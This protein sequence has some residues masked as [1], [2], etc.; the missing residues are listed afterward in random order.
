MNFV[1]EKQLIKFPCTY[2]PLS[3]FKIFIK[4][5]RVDSEDVRHFWDQN[6]PSVLNKIF[7]WYKPL[8]LLSSN[9]GP[10]HCAKFKINLTMDPEL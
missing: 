6:R 1:P 4:E 3:F 8:L 5:L 7:V 10:F 2:Q 9:Y